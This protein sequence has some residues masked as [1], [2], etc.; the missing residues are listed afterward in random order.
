[1]N[2]REAIEK[3]Q[4]L[5]RRC[6]AEELQRHAHDTWVRAMNEAR[7]AQ[8]VQDAIPCQVLGREE[9]DPDTWRA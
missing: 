9:I 5:L 1:M 7:D 3:A 4:D 2:A 8:A 6:S